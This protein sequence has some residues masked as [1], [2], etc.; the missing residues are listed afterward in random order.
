MLLL[1]PEVALEHCATILAVPGTPVPKPSPAQREA[2][3]GWAM[4]TSGMVLGVLLLAL[5][6]LIVIGRQRRAM[7]MPIVGKRKKHRTRID[8]W[9][10]S[11]KRLP[12]PDDGSR[13]DTVDIH[14]DE[15]GPDDQSGSPWDGPD[16]PRNGPGGTGD[17]GGG[18]S[19]R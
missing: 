15:L 11:G 10:E 7:L 2:V 9:A 19:V 13:D 4:L 18:G 3:K 17:G 14:P 16:S 6:A 1:M 8:P 12:T 5:V